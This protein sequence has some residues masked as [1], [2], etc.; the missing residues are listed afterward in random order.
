MVQPEGP[1]D[2]IIRR[3]QIAGWIT[4]ATDTHTEYA[5]LTAFP[6]Q[7]WTCLNVTLHVHCLS[8]YN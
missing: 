1:H 3:M 8:C 6:R 4:K 5:I 7:Q 2:N